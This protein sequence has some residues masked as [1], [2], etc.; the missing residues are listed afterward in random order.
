MT[1]D[2]HAVQYPDV[3]RRFSPRQTLMRYASYLVIVFIAVWSISK[4]DIPWFYFLDAHVQAKDLAVRMWP[5]DW[6]F[7]N[8]LVKPFFDCF[9]GGI[10]GGPQYDI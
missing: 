4:L 10:S 9:S 7:A 5:P 8:Q 6:G 2:E 3:W 1:K